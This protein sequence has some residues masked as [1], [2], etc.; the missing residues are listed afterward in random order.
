MARTHSIEATRAI[1][2][3]VAKGRN[4][5]VLDAMPDNFIM[6]LAKNQLH[7]TDHLIDNEYVKGGKIYNG[8]KDQKTK[9]R[10]Q[11]PN[12]KKQKYHPKKRRLNHERARC[13]KPT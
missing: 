8:V 7:G 1:G 4:E 6:D 11:T 13:T 3:L 2:E 12:H 5:K 10:K 9:S